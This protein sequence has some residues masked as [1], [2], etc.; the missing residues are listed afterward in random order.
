M[1]IHGP[2][3]SILT[4]KVEDEPLC[5]LAVLRK[6]CAELGNRNFGFVA[7]FGED[8]RVERCFPKLADSKLGL[9]AR[10]NLETVELALE[11]RAR[12]LDPSVLEILLR[13]A[14][15]W[16]G[17]AREQPHVCENRLEDDLA[18]TPDE[19]EEVVPTAHAVDASFRLS[20]GQVVILR[21]DA[22]SFG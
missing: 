20:G 17:R 10:G 22:L 6:E 7:E 16:L 2:E 14:D 12:P 3:V 5:A 21:H 9:L 8:G 4:T 11:I 18:L 19:S 15:G 1:R 13:G